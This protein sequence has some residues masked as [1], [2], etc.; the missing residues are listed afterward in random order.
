MKP[1]ADFNEI[2]ASAVLEMAG[3]SSLPTT[4]DRVVHLVLETVTS[5]DAVAVKV[6][7]QGVPSV[8][9]ATDPTLEDLLEQHV[10]RGS[11]PLFDVYRDGV[12]LYVPDVTAETRWPVYS[13]TLSEN[14]GLHTV[15]VLPLAG[16]DKPAGVLGLYAKAVDA[17]DEDDK[18]VANILLAHAAAAL[19]DAVGQTQLRTA[20]DSRTVIG[21]ATGVLMERFALQPS[22]AFGV[23]RRISQ[24]HNVKLRD[25][26]TQVVETGRLPADPDGTSP[27][28]N[29]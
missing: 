21:Q 17:F 15:Y 16:A 29:A 11:A 23:L 27:D 7:Q 12:A 1:P 4:V 3:E 5:C 25:V 6:F 8:L 26:A 20:L 22:A 14:L 19:A 2:L 13:R 24:S 28:G 9:A 10:T 18:A